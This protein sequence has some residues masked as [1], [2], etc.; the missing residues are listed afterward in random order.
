[1]ILNKRHL[2]LRKVQWLEQLDSIPWRIQTKESKKKKTAY[3]ERASFSP[4]FVKGYKWIHIICFLSIICIS[5][6]HQVVC[7]A[8]RLIIIHH[9]RHKSSNSDSFRGG[10]R[11]RIVVRKLRNTIHGYFDINAMDRLESLKK[12]LR[13][14]CSWVTRHTYRRRISKGL[15]WL[16]PRFPRLT[17]F[18]WWQL[19][20]ACWSR[21]KWRENNRFLLRHST[22]VW[23]NPSV[24]WKHSNP[25]CSIVLVHC[26]GWPFFLH[27]AVTHI[28]R[29]AIFVLL[30][31][32]GEWKWPVMIGHD[33]DAS[34]LNTT[35]KDTL[36]RQFPLDSS[37]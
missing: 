28:S 20:R 16:F 17:V 6:L 26:G 8:G 10:V 27:W 24:K 35:T 1:M 33:D 2:S 31:V 11:C 36:L 4:R 5:L 37:V 29:F 3:Q 30:V 22:V 9:L 21:N 34:V 19:V 14:S 32:G 15:L 25:F 18:E 23:H 13:T 7:S 12:N